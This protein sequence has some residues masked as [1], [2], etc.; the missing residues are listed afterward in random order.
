MDLALTGDVTDASDVGNVTVAYSDASATSDGACF[1][2][3]IVIRTWTATDACGN[4]TTKEQIITLVDE[5][6]PYFTSVPAGLIRHAE[7]TCHSLMQQQPML[8]PL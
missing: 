4:C 8:V 5:N 7:T 2:N 6:A 3:D 1:A